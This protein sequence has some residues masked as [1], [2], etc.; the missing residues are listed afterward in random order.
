MPFFLVEFFVEGN[1]HFN[2][3]PEVWRVEASCKKLAF[4]V[5]VKEFRKRF[6]FSD[7]K[8]ICCRVDEVV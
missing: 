8:L 7:R 4:G 3:P 6:G 5:A 2:A 1:K